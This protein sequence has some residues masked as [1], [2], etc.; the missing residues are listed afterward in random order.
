MKNT[1]ER[2]PDGSCRYPT[3][4]ELAPGTLQDNEV[5]VRV[6]RA[7][8]PVE[9]EEILEQG[10]ALK[11]LPEAAQSTSKNLVQHRIAIIGHGV[12]EGAV[13]PT[14]ATTTALA[15][16][17]LFKQLGDDAYWLPQVEVN[18]KS[19]EFKVIQGEKVGKDGC[20]YP[21]ELRIDYANPLQEGEKLVKVTRA[22][23]Q[24]EC[25]VLV[26]IGIVE[27]DLHK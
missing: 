8:D 3:H 19:S 9:C 21:S 25:I 17:D 2:L 5:F 11:P 27:G 26:E 20:R 4:I 23:N 18:F 16:E 1:G 24:T 7:F 14:A 15:Q 12:R 13:S 10:I 22:R 6:R